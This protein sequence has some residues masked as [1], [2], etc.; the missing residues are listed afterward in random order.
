MDLKD[1][2]FGGEEWMELAYDCSQWRAIVLMV[3]K[4]RTVLTILLHAH[5]DK[6]E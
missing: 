1:S 5:N 6:R 2:S 3:L 4:R